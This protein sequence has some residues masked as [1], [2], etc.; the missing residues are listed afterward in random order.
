MRTREMK[1]EFMML[2]REYKVNREIV[3][4]ELGS[5]MYHSRGV[6]AMNLQRKVLLGLSRHCQQRRL[7]RYILGKRFKEVFHRVRQFNKETTRKVTQFQSKSLKS[8]FFSAWKELYR[9]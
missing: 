3:S 2:L 1:S 6:Y 4:L 7:D 8:Y 5:E 9:T